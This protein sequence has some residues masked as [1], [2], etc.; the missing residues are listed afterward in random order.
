VIRWGILLAACVTACGL[1]VA[2]GAPTEPTDSDAGPGASLPERGED[3]ASK[4]A[5]VDAPDANGEPDADAGPTSW[6][7]TQPAHEVCV[8]FDDGQLVLTPYAFG[9]VAST[10]DST[11]SRSAP[12]SL[13]SEATVPGAATYVFKSWAGTR[14]T[15]DMAFDVLATGEGYAQI[16]GLE[17]FPTVSAYYQLVFEYDNGALSFIEVTT[18]KVSHPLVTTPGWH[19]LELHAEMGGAADKTKVRVSA[20]GVQ[21][22]KGDVTADRSAV[23]TI[24]ADVGI[25][26]CAKA[27]PVTLFVDNVTIDSTP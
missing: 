17:I 21:Y 16:G 14:S 5:T 15:I 22:F 11:Q 23:A 18:T 20:D 12:S 6:C 7:A 13:K 1:A 27:S 26:Y 2:G 3:P 19:H 4:D 9:A 10:I 24:K 8:D 25:L